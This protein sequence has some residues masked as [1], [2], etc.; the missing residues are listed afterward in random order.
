MENN[1]PFIIFEKRKSNLKDHSGEISLP[2][3]KFS[4]KDRNLEETALRETEE[5]LGLKRDNIILIGE[6][7]DMFTITSRYI[8]TPFVGELKNFNNIKLKINE[9]EVEEAFSVPIRI[10]L[11]KSNFWERFWTIKG[12]KIPIY[13]YRYKN[14][15]I[16]GATGYI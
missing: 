15:I 2:G 7:D 8:I 16:W 12:Q 11:D 6:L 3:G 9:D 4:N 13:Y 10:F 5:E 14:Y 1:E